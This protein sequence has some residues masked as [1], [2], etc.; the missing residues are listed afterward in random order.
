MQVSFLRYSRYKY[1]KPRRGGADGPASWERS[2]QRPYDSNTADRDVHK[3]VRV[4]RLVFVGKLTGCG[5][6]TTLKSRW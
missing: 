1:W 5:A 2:E 3:D 6:A 4:A